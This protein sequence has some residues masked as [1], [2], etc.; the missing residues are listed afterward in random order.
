MKKK[1]KKLPSIQTTLLNMN[2][3]ELEIKVTRIKNS[4]HARLY[5]QGS[6]YDEMS[7]TDRRDV[8]KICRIMMRWL[9]KTGSGNKHT[10]SA[11][12]RLNSDIGFFGAVRY[13]NEIQRNKLK[14]S[15]KD[16]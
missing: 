6:C 7:C 4:W 16:K 2:N 11:R 1:L 8:G 9:D 12:K 14:N 15:T 13:Q 10:K 5:V 3:S